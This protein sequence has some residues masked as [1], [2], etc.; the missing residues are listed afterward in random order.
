MLSNASY[1]EICSGPCLVRCFGIIEDRGAILLVCLGLGG[2]LR[3][4]TFWVKIGIVPGKPARL[5]TTVRGD[6]LA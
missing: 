4:G 2:F 3:C 1:S 6:Q 5:V